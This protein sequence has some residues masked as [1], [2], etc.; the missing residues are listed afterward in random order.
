MVLLKAFEWFDSIKTDVHFLDLLGRVG[1][2]QAENFTSTYIPT[3]WSS[4][5]DTEL[6][7]EKDEK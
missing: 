4:A 3:T 7:T 2:P 5:G 6:V 1:I